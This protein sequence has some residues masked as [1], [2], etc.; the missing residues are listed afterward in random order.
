MSGMGGVGGLTRVPSAQNFTVPPMAV[1]VEP[2]RQSVE[3]LRQSVEPL[4][5]S[6]EPLRQSVEP[7]PYAEQRPATPEMPP[8][9]SDSDDGDYE[10]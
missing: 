5:Q 7:S 2:L 4:R 6:V 1:Y 8:P 3:P 9:D 10:D